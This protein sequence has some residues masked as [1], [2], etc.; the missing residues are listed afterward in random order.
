VI[1]AEFDRAAQHAAHGA[2]IARRA[3]HA[4][5]GE[6]HRS[7]ANAVDGLVADEGCLVHV[8]CWRFGARLDTRTQDL[9]TSWGFGA[10]GRKR[11]VLATEQA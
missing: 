7:K 6:L 4:G 2:R 9:Q 11:I 3:K 8:D 10:T 5:A 1:D